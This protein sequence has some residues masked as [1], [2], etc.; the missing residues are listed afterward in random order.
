MVEKWL[1]QVEDMMISSL[2]HI[3]KDAV[4]DYVVK[5]RKKWVLDWP[6]QVVLC[7]S[8]VYWTEETGT[9][10]QNNKLRNYLET[11]SNQ[12]NDTV[13]LVRG[14]LDSGARITLGALIV[15][16]VHGKLIN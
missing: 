16:D 1:Q 5:D 15:I 10:I 2:R 8:Q 6:G 4:A 12:I 14:K 3:I 13:A 11:C 9:A 7:A